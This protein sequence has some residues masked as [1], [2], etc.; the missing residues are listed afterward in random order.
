MEI[1]ENTGKASAKGSEEFISIADIL[2][3]CISKW[4][5][6][7]AS[8]LITLT[9]GFLYI[10]MTPPTY[11]RTA[12][13]MVKDDSKGVLSGSSSAFEEIGLMQTKTNVNNEIIS[14]T[15]SDVMTEVV[16][17][18]GLSVSYKADG[19]F[20]DPALY[21]RTLPFT[22]S[23]PDLG[24]SSTASFTVTMSGDAVTLNDFMSDGN[25]FEDAEVSGNLGDTLDTPAGKVIISRNPY[26]PAAP[27]SKHIYV[28]KGSLVDVV[29]AYT[30]ALNVYLKDEK[31]SVVDLSISDV[32]V[33]RAEDILNTIIAVYNEKWMAD[34]N[35]V[36]VSTSNFIDE[37]LAIIEKELGNVEENI[38]EYKSKNLLPDLQ[39]ASSMYQSQS[40][41]TASR[42]IE[43][44]TQI[45][46]ARYIKSYMSASSDS[47]RLFPSNSGLDNP[48]IATQ[49]A[50]YNAMVLERNSLVSNSSENNPLVADMDRTLEAMRGA[51]MTSIDEQIKAMN[52]QLEDLQKTEAA[53][54]ERIAESPS[55][56]KYLLSVERQQK[57]KESLYLFLL[58]KREENELSQAFTAYNTRIINQPSGS[59]A[60]VSPKSR[61]ILLLA[62]LIGLI[63]PVAVIFLL[64]LL[65]TRIRSRKDL[66]WLSVPFI[67]EIPLS[68]K[69]DRHLI[70]KW[71]KKEEKREIVV[72]EK[73]RNM[74]NEAFRV[75]RTNFEFILG[76]DSRVVMFTSMNQGSGKTFISMNLAMSFAIK[77]KKTVLLDLDLRKA[78]LSEFISSPKRGVSDY[79]NGRV[80]D[81]R[82]V[83]V[84]GKLHPCLDII[85]VGTLP[86]N[87]AELLYEDR[88]KTMMDSLRS[89]YDYVFIDCPPVEIVADSS[90]IA[91]YVDMTVFIARA[92]L[93]EKAALPVI[94]SYYTEKK[95]HAMAIILNGTEVYGGYGYRRYGSY[96]Y[97]HSYGYGKGYLENE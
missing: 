41:E 67:G 46:L 64:E 65:N 18:L 57:V 45:S 81:Y 52:I 12:S 61:T 87:P 2:N 6:F 15:S 71:K 32:S 25:R 36:A 16:K 14:M 96:G 33:Q 93:L 37:R 83:L 35:Q 51:I 27:A 10:R 55:Q 68:Y 11:V 20:Y 72:R 78:A 59:M 43:L 24:N 42:I 90:I 13:I 63:I 62:F 66:E 70:R 31:A 50:N 9:A 40:S 17:R 22:V 7:V 77:G 85:P 73:K 76:K 89:E 80:E 47:F 88:M 4:Y 34:R 26:C 21:G 23:F 82:E 5:W 79:L 54:R 56:A 74:I 38:S 29:A 86:P 95:F 75:V 69:K 60:P 94:E 97:G 49:V 84:K 8:L 91:E 48:A 44:N 1:I 92:D 53:L 30:K 39:S 19:S 28:S 58:Q 3:I